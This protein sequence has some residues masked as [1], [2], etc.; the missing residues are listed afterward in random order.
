M[1]RIPRPDLRTRLTENTRRFLQD[2]PAYFV[3]MRET[4]GDIFEMG[5]LRPGV[6]GITH[7]DYVRHVLVGNQKNYIKDRPTRTLKLSLGN[8]LL[9]SEG[10][11]W[12]RQRRIAQPAFHRQ[13]LA[14]MVEAMT[15]QTEAMLERWESLE[16]PFDLAQEMMVLTS[17]IVTETLFGADLKNPRSD[18]KSHPSQ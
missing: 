3:H 4:Y 10:E 9:T 1:K 5:L 17:R 7:P 12:R 16:G 11:F 18:W 13:R 8:G 6:F 15:R 14:G 2:P